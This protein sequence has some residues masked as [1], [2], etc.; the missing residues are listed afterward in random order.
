MI[1]CPSCNTEN[2]PD[3]Q[4][5]ISCGAKLVAEEST[6]P[7]SQPIVATPPVVQPPPPSA[8][9]PPPAPGYGPPP[10]YQPPPYPYVQRPPKD[11]SIALILEILPNLFGFFGF[12][13]IYAGNTSVGII[14]LVSVLAW[15]FMA[16]IIVIFTGGFGCFCTVP[17]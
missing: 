4:F 3:S 2:K 14:W 13:W 12:G 16:A 6:P 17:V 1:I 15:D 7:A 9:Y 5:C 8:P 11:R 10:G